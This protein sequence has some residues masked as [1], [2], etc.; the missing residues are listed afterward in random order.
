M[1]KKKKDRKFWVPVDDGF[2]S[3]QAATEG[4]WHIRNHSLDALTMVSIDTIWYIDRHSLWTY[5][6][7]TPAY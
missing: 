6:N 2:L 4:L 7:S 1:G 3:H 5:Q